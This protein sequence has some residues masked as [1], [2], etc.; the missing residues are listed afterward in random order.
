MMKIL[1]IQALASVQDLGRSGWRELGIGQAGAMDPLALK[2]G[3]LLV[4]N[5]ENAAAVEVILGGMTVQ[6][7]YDTPFCITGAFYEAYLDG[8]P[9]YSYWRYTAKAG[10]ILTLVRAKIGMYGYLCICGGFQVPHELGSA[11]TDNRTGLGGIEGRYLR[12]GDAVPTLTRHNTLS[13]I[14]V[15]PIAW[16]NTIYAVPSSEYDA[17][18]AESQRLW[19]Q[20]TWILQGSSDRMG[21]RFKGESLQLKAPL[22]M[23]SHAIQFG[24]VQVPPNGQPI[25]L[26]ADA[27]TTGGYPKIA[28]VVSADLGRLAQVR[29]GGEIK[30][31]LADMQTVEKLHKENDIYLNHIRRIAYEAD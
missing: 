18:T 31:Y 26:M 7:D 30:F 20:R 3:N 1:D 29:F 28:T 4:R 25:I 16:R 8:E 22:E 12:Q 6:F 11:S 10:Q 17:F 5:E 2:A 23:L 14:G 13:T 15:A 21:Y 27:Q 19:W 24:T 9:I